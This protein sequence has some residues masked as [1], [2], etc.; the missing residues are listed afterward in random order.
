MEQT[1]SYTDISDLHHVD[2]TKKTYNFITQKYY[3]C[4]YICT[5]G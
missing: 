3:E 2:V 1:D 5:K 4:C